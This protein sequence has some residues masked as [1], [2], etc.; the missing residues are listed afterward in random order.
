MFEKGCLGLIAAAAVLLL[1]SL[2]RLGNSLNSTILQVRTDAHTEALKL[3]ATLTDLDRDAVIASGTLTHIEKAS[4]EWQTKQNQLA[5]QAITATST[6][7]ADL[8]QA[9]QLLS[10]ANS[11]AE[12]QQQSLTALEGTAGE[13]LR[14][15]TGS[16]ANLVEQAQPGLNN[17]TA[18]S[19]DLSAGINRTMP[20]IQGMAADGHTETSLI[21]K[22]T[23]EAFKPKNKFLA[24]L[25][26][27]GG[28]TINAAELYYYLSH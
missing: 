8:T 6:L 27:L 19:A 18:A 26:M 5:D 25:Q 7:T 2:A 16:F 3:D 1:L 10:T 21:V 11:L 15:V 17:F 23:K 28:G 9:G 4:R 24:I 22:Q 13:S 20:E 14:T 12:S